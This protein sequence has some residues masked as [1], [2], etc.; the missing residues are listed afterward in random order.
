MRCDA[1][2]SD[3]RDEKTTGDS[4]SPLRRMCQLP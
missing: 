1:P 3:V 4:E 2:Q